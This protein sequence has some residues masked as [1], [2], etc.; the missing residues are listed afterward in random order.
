MAIRLENIES[1]VL[2]GAD[3][4][5]Q[6][7]IENI[8]GSLCAVMRLINDGPSPVI[9]S[10]PGTNSFVN[11][12]IR[13]S[14]STTQVYAKIL[15]KRPETGGIRLRTEFIFEPGNGES[16][17]YVGFHAS[18]A[19]TTN[20]SYGWAQFG[21]CGGDDDQVQ[22]VNAVLDVYD[23]WGDAPIG[24]TAVMHL[25]VASSS[26]SDEIYVGSQYTTGL[27]GATSYVGAP[28]VVT[29]SHIPN[30]I[31]QDNPLGS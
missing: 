3:L 26:A 31:K 8:P 22:K 20:P 11:P 12:N 15:V 10:T 28:L 7:L 14:V 27:T 1:T 17:L 13:T 2:G 4:T 23:T 16:N 9:F 5:G 18:A 6:Q 25:M 29:A 21:A 24:A 30:Y 19:A